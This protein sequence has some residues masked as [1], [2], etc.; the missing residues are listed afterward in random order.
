M[1]STSRAASKDCCADATCVCDWTRA[2]KVLAAER[3]ADGA[4]SVRMRVRG[5]DIAEGALETVFAPFVRLETSRSRQ[6]GG[7][8]LGLTIARAL[9]E[10]DGAALRLRNLR[11]GCT[12]R[13]HR[14][15]AERS[16]LGARGA[17][18]ATVDRPCRHARRWRARPGEE[19]RPSDADLDRSLSLFGRQRSQAEA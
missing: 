9:A 7:A 3:D 1:R 15:G 8:G 14:A 18:P 5:P 16:G 2:D 4:L 6:T 17:A 13:R 10:K 11:E 12:G 19:S